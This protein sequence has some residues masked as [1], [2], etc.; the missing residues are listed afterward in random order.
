MSSLVAS[1]SSGAGLI[2]DCVNVM[3]TKEV[4]SRTRLRLATALLH[5]PEMETE[6]E[7]FGSRRYVDLMKDQVDAF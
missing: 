2:K 4:R 7:V 6:L 5:F 3:T 1:L